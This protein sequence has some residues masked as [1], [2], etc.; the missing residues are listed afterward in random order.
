MPNGGFFGFFL[1]IFKKN[2]APAGEA[3]EMRVFGAV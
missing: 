3:P 1:R 2:T